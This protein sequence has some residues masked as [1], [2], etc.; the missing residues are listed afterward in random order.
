MVL[1]GSPT[2]WLLEV[3]SLEIK[4][5]EREGNWTVPAIADIKNDFTCAPVIPVPFCD[6]YGDNFILPLPL[7][8]WL[9]LVCY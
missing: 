7:I 4:R 1:T 2:E 3:I 5:P 8:F 9:L 6:V